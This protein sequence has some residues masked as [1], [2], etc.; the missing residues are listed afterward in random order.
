MPLRA[1]DCVLV[2]GAAGFIG[3]DLVDHLLESG[4]RVRA[5]VRPARARDLPVTERLAAAPGDLRDREALI[6]AVAGVQAVA[7]LGARKADEP[8]SVEVNVRGAERL[9]EACQRKGVR[10]LVNV[11]T[12]SVKLPRAGT[13]GRTKGEA[14]RV[15]HASGLDVTSLR[16]SVVYGP[17][18]TGVFARMRHFMIRLPVLPVIGDGR[19][20]SRPIHVRDVSRA[21]RACLESDATIGGIYDLGGPDEV[22]MDEFL[23]MIGAT[24]GIRRRKLHIPASLGLVAASVLSRLMERPPVTVSNVL[25]S[26]Q[27]ASCDPSRAVAALGI[28]PVGIAEGLDRMMDEEVRAR[29][30]G[31]GPV[32]KAAVVGLGK[33]G[34]F[35]AA[36]LRT[37]PNVRLVGMVDSNR[38][39]ETTARSMGLQAP[40]FPS[41]DEL[42]A[43]RRV[44][45]AL[46]CTPTSSHYDAVRACLT[47]G[48]HVLV[49]KPLTEVATRSQELADLADRAGR[50]HAVGYHL[51][52]SPIFERART[53]LTE[54][55]LGPLRAFQGTLAHAEVLGPKKGWMFDTARSGGGLVRNTASHLIFL[56][57]W[58]FGI[59]AR[60]TAKTTRVHSTSIED[61]VSATLEYASGLI[62]TLEASWSVPGKTIM[63]VQLETRGD[64]GSLIVDGTNIWLDLNQPAPGLAAGQHRIHASGLRVE[65]VYDLA[66]DAGGAAYY[67]QDHGF[68]EDCREGRRSRTAFDVAARA[69]RVIDAIYGSSERAGPVLLA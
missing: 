53:L 48:V 42:L 45:A 61:A 5:F 39:L 57:E 33:M 41:L 43:A 55:A 67:R 32:L 62:G 30:G 63:E 56:L 12:Q 21:V 69:E 58:F 19:W 66:P 16:P 46:V 54:G 6:E 20:R 59:P 1:G 52:Y 25:G 38:A 65:G 2:T 18:V 26:T 29:H 27:E 51:P 34:L 9:A 60:V 64:R 23:D 36:L 50:V 35:H 44:D 15:L 31:R 28:A 3:R 7:H 10:R 13:Y 68:V 37:I 49:E 4:Y 11:S 47:R 22:S 40:F 14:E 17:D 8:D 24:L